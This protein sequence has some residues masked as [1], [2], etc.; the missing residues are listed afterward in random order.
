MSKKVFR[1]ICR[2]GV[3]ACNGVLFHDFFKAR[4]FR[5][6]LYACADVIVQNNVF[7]PFV[8]AEV[9]FLK[10]DF[11]RIRYLIFCGE[12][13]SCFGHLQSRRKLLVPVKPSAE[14]KPAFRR[15]I[16]L[17]KGMYVFA[18]FKIQRRF[19]KAAAVKI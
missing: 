6:R 8:A 19:R 11:R 3:L 1:R 9:E 13:K 4:H 16:C 10:I 15:R 7:R 12:R 17:H 5:L 14:R 2:Q 18:R